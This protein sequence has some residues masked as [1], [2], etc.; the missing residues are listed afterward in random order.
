MHAWSMEVARLREVAGGG[1]ESTVEGG[2]RNFEQSLKKKLFFFHR[3]VLHYWCFWF[4]FGETHALIACPRCGDVLAKRP[5]LELI[6]VDV[7][8]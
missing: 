3:K 2:G 7:H 5:L 8:A 4:V 6:Y 1:V